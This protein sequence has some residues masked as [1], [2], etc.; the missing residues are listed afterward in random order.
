MDATHPN[1]RLPR[2]WYSAS[3]QDFLTQSTETVLGFLARHSALAMEP[4]QRD[5]WLETI[6]LLKQHLAGRAGHLLLEFNIPRMG[7]R[8]DAVLLVG[9]ALVMLEFKVNERAA[10]TEAK[11]QAWE[12]ALDTKNF[13]EPSHALPIVPVLIPTEYQASALPAIHFAADGVAAPIA[14]GADLL[15][16]LLDALATQY[17]APLDA[18][19]W[20]AGRYK[21]T[22]T[23]IEAARHLY[24]NH[25]VAD[26]VRTE[27]DE[28]NLSDTARRVESLIERARA[29]GEKIIIF[30]TGVPGAG[31]TLVGLNIATSHRE[32]SDTHAVFLGRHAPLR[33]CK[34]ARRKQRGERTSKATA[35][36]RIKAFIQNV[37]P[38]A[39][40]H[41]LTASGTRSFFASA[42]RRGRSLAIPGKV[43]SD[44]MGNSRCTLAGPADR[45]ATN[46]DSNLSALGSRHFKLDGRRQLAEHERLVSLKCLLEFSG[47]TNYS[48]C[49]L[50]TNWLIAFHH[51][52]WACRRRELEGDCLRRWVNRN[53]RRRTII[54]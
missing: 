8:V 41:L 35:S 50:T 9:G 7:L 47:R 29:Q 13:H 33:D 10:S 31:K 1:P 52:L 43:E 36:K 14:M 23:I 19:A 54:Q 17:P 48:H 5:A 2:A 32:Q 3:I 39:P 42:I 37:Q 21:P 40:R 49:K 18:A 26:I 34:G 24:A 11:N 22:P 20:I 46:V 4:L 12:Y 30:V 25:S 45:D 6:H 51:H 15:P 16:Q 44:A 38:Q 53:D 27:A 28:R